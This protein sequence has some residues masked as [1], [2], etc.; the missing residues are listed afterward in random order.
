MERIILV[1][2]GSPKKDANRMDLVGKL[3]HSQMHPGCGAGCVKI[4][5]LQHESP[6]LADAIE[7]AVSEGAKRIVLHPYFLNSG[8]HVTEDIPRIIGEAKRKYGGVKFVYTEPLGVSEGIVRVVMDRINAATGIASGEIEKES[9]KSIS[10]EID[11]SGLHEE[12]RPIITRVIH[13]TADFGYINTLVFHPRAVKAG[14]AAIKA[15]KDI[16]TD[17]AMIRAGINK[18]LLKRW[19]GKVVCRINEVPFAG[20]GTRAEAA[21]EEALAGDNIGIVA[22][23]NAPTALLRCIDMVRSGKAKPD[24]V[25]GVPVGFIRAEESKAL[26]CEQ[27]FPYISNIGRKGGSPVAAAIVNALLK[28]TETEG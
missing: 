27:K 7:E 19:G 23:G 18:R 10:G 1:G 14:V 5:Y 9:F 15:G 8:V 11:L 17:V 20:H 26:L 6:T 13:A 3:L 22:I 12:L 24:L 25:V 16:V 21:I 4:S 2:H 28:M